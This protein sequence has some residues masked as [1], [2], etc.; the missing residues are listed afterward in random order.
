MSEYGQGGAPL[1]ILRVPGPP[2]LLPGHFLDPLAVH[3]TTLSYSL[4]FPRE[5]RSGVLSLDALRAQKKII[6]FQIFVQHLE[7]KSTVARRSQEDQNS[8]K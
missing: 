7:K 2:G 4:P 6:K 8:T 3:Q 5:R 1:V